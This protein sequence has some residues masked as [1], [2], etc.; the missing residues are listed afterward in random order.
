MISVILLIF[1]LLLVVIGGICGFCRGILKEGV[2]T[3]LWAVL[4]FASLF[5][6]PL[7]S[8]AVFDFVFQKMSLDAVTVEQLI[9]QY[10]NQVD[11]LKVEPA[12]VNSLAALVRKRVNSDA[13]SNTLLYIASFCS[14]NS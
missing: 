7:I 12:L 4:F 2:R 9:E 8:D 14:F 10:L 11:Y 1:T 6:I 5:V 3:A 13:F